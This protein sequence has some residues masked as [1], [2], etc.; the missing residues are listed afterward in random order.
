M[1]IAST[2]ASKYVLRD[3][4]L[5]AV[6]AIKEKLTDARRTVLAMSCGCGKTFVAA[7]VAA[8]HSYVVVLSPLQAIAEQNLDRFGEVVP[9]VRLLVDSEGE[10]DVKTLVK[11][12]KT[13][14]KWLL[15]ATFKS[16]DVIWEALNKSK[17]L[18][19]TIFIVDEFHG[20]S[21]PD[22][23]DPERPMNK[24]LE[25]NARGLHLSATPRVYEIASENVNDKIS[26]Y[27]GETAYKIPLSEAIQRKL[28][29]DYRVFCPLIGE[30]GQEQEVYSEVAGIKDASE[31]MLA[32]AMFLLRGML[33]QGGR[34]AIAYFSS[35]AAVE[36]FYDVLTKVAVEYF[37]LGDFW[38]SAILSG[39]SRATRKDRLDKFTRHQGIAVICNVLILSEAID[40]PACDCIFMGDPCHSRVR[41]VQ[42]VC[43]ANRLD[44]EHPNKIAKIFVWAD[45][46]DDLLEFVASLKEID[47]DF[48]QKLSVLSR[49]YERTT[50]EK[51]EQ[52][53]IAI[54][55]SIKFCLKV[56]EYQ[57]SMTFEQRAMLK[58][59][60]LVAW[61]EDH[62]GQLPRMYAKGNEPAEERLGLFLN[63]YR[64]A[65]RGT[66][67]NVHTYSSVD[68]LLDAKLSGWRNAW[69]FKA[70]RQARRVVKWITDRHLQQLPN[71]LSTEPVEK[72]L[73]AFLKNYRMALVGANKG[74]VQENVTNILD[75][76]IPYWRA[77]LEFL[78]RAKALAYIAFNQQHQRKPNVEGDEVES[79]LATW[80]SKYSRAS[81]T[82]GTCCRR[83]S[84]IDQ[85]LSSENF[86]CNAN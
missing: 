53:K 54:A 86:N 52:L 72:E 61:V 74:K 49:R 55:N 80:I 44:P 6:E 12:M 75:D 69:E 28:V 8:D 58:A 22:I 20:L 38:S 43:R 60:Q 40:V 25:S 68:G 36:A 65:D 11:F 17:K 39:D 84:S 62:D 7:T 76:G 47:P 19:N 67:T 64:M 23:L 70:M 4:Q 31:Q 51:K 21:K 71:Y 79:V 48:C 30:E 81:Y 78:G 83:Y 9:H 56:R 59:Q 82:G 33:D 66:N 18:E 77:P 41:N 85:L 37:G 3:Y 26:K 16:A 46:D 35:H 63:A 57:P 2:S 50:S 29:T 34:K 24:L 13:N 73:G 15:S 5:E 1:Q 42:R 45:Q 32:K 10:R 27:F 14:K